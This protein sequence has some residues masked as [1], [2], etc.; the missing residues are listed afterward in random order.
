MDSFFWADMATALFNALVQSMT[1][2]LFAMGLALILG[3]LRILNFAHGAYFMV[4]AYIAYSLITPIGPSVSAWTFAGVALVT[5][6]IVGLFGVVAERVLFARLRNVDYH[7]SLIGTYALLLA[8]EGAAKLVWGVNFLAVPVPDEFRGALRAGF[9]IMP[10][11]SIAIVVTGIASFF[12]LDHLLHRTRT[13]KLMQSVA[14]DPWMANALGVN[15]PRVYASI[16]VISFFLAGLAGAL[17]APSQALSPELAN[18]LALPAFGAL[19]VGGMGNV[20][21]TLVAAMILSGIDTI[22][23]FY[24]GQTPGIAFFLAVCVILVIRPQGLFSSIHL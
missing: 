4:G 2:F 23:S 11:F 14:L 16:V 13:G 8:T 19:I 21:G 17:L 15:V 24:L 18:S 20:K 22:G 3:V 12:L 6:L 5:G 7:Y 10:W 1:V 9:V